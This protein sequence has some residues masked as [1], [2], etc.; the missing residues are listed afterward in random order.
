MENKGKRLVNFLIPNSNTMIRKKSYRK[1]SAVKELKTMT[2]PAARKK[3][4][5]IPSEWLAARKYHDDTSIGLTRCIIDFI[6]FNGCQAEGINNTDRIIDNQ[7]TF[8]DVI[9]QRR[10]VGQKKWI[11]ATGTN[12]TADISATI[13]GCSVKIGVKT[14]RDKQSEKQKQYQIEIEAVGGYYLITRDFDSF[15]KWHHKFNK[16]GHE[17]NK[18]FTISFSND[19]KFQ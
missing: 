14:G 9:G 7:K 8:I 10:T 6:R 5:G 12:W 17:K 2:N 3:F 4:P 11:L 13:A 1:F 18:V 19:K 16:E 15:L